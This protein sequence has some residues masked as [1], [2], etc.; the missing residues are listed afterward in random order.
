MHILNLAIQRYG[1]LKASATLTI[2]KEWQ[3]QIF[4]GGSIQ[5]RLNLCKLK[6]SATLTLQKEWQTQIFVGG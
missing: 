2:Q 3:T 6:A 1:K 5:T 4:V